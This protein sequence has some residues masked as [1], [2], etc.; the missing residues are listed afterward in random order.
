MESLKEVDKQDLL[1]HQSYDQFGD[2]TIL[3]IFSF[4]HSTEDLVRAG[5]VSRQWNKVARDHTLWPKFLE[6]QGLFEWVQPRYA[7]EEYRAL[8]IAACRSE[9]KLSSDK[10]IS[11]PL[12]GNKQHLVKE[13]RWARVGQSHFLVGV[14]RIGTKN[15]YRDHPSEVW[16]WK[17]PIGRLI[18][19]WRGNGDE[20]FYTLR[21]MPYT[22]QL[23][24]LAAVADSGI[25]LWDVNSGAQIPSLQPFKHRVAELLAISVGEMWRLVAVRKRSSTQDHSV[26]YTIAVWDPMVE[27]PAV[28]FSVDNAIPTI[29]A[30]KWKNE[31]CLFIGDRDRGV[32]VW[33]PLAGEKIAVFS[34]PF[35]EITIASL[36]WLCRMTW[37]PDRNGDG[38]LVIW[39]PLIHG[40]QDYIQLI[41][42]DKKEQCFALVEGYFG[43]D[44]W[45]R[46]VSCG[47]EIAK[48]DGKQVWFWNSDGKIQ[49]SCGGMTTWLECNSNEEHGFATRFND[50]TYYPFGYRSEFWLNT[51][52]HGAFLSNLQISALLGP[53]IGLL[54]EP[55][56][57]RG[58]P[59]NETHQ[60]DISDLMDRSKPEVEKNNCTIA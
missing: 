41:D 26:T 3:N 25:W 57:T 38:K 37:L 58:E 55:R 60:L 29:T 8:E 28:Y 48:G 34:S 35:S 50:H 43:R 5:G 54:V 59:F 27:K 4:I 49:K 33:D 23:V 15:E 17:L 32:Q 24:L 42:L 12:Q 45:I 13:Y 36:K 46:S 7:P 30:G 19:Q 51:R 56:L 52:S 44:S 9:E 11:K 21:L 1:P 6:R 14:V 53:G 39:H 10:R 31:T 20:S 2:E 47:I 40:K 18:H 22:D 16:C